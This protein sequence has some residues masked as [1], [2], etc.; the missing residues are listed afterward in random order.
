MYV[1]RCLG[2]KAWEI[3]IFEVSMADYNNLVQNSGPQFIRL[4]LK[5]K[6]AK[7]IYRVFILCELRKPN[8]N[9]ETIV[10]LNFQ[11]PIGYWNQKLISKETRYLKPVMSIY[12]WI[13]TMYYTNS[14]NV[15]VSTTFI[16]KREKMIGKT[17]PLRPNRTRYSLLIQLA[18]S[19][20]NPPWVKTN[21]AISKVQP[22][23]LYVLCIF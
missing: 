16:F 18:L 2:K 1:I 11:L 5:R 10:Y 21:L 7:F 13:N 8:T 14:P 22:L 20:G 3:K 19:H 23:S 9:Y 4:I 15:K 17:S 6:F 12:E